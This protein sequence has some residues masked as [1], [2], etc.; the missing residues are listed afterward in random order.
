MARFKVFRG[1]SHTPF[2]A[3]ISWRGIAKDEK[4]EEECRNHGT[5]SLDPAQC[6]SV[7]PLTVNEM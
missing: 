4:V 5:Y 1:L 7:Q 3:S 6:L 2:S